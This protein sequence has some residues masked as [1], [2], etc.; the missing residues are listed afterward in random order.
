MEIISKQEAISRGLK[1]YF[2]GKT[3]AK[4]HVAERNVSSRGCLA[5]MADAVAA[6]K[7]TSKGRAAVLAYVHSEERKAQQRAEYATPEWKA[8]AQEYRK[9]D[10][11]RAVDARYRA[12]EKAKLTRAKYDSSERRKA[13]LREY[14]D[15][16]GY[17][18]WMKSPEG[19]AC[20]RAGKAARRARKKAAT[21]PLTKEENARIRAFY[22]E[23]SR[24]TKET[25]VK[26]Q[27]DHTLPLVRGG[28]H[29]P[30]NMQVVTEAYN[31]SKQDLT[32]EEFRLSRERGY[33]MR[34]D[35]D[36]F[37]PVDVNA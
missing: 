8:W 1:R 36:L 35:N 29:H 17:K 4:G 24:L 7:Q 20:L 25:G 11:G 21:V 5:C 32:E 15:R 22:A 33:R 30:N 9:S 27:V 18:A 10:K 26:H 19:I 31:A 2:T 16:A 13:L 37:N 3:C 28:L 34:L 14:N 23:A 12:T 6:Y